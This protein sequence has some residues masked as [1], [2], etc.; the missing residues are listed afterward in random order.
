MKNI[1]QLSENLSKAIQ[2]IKDESQR[3]MVIY[4]GDLSGD[5]SDRVINTQRDNKG[6]LFSKY[7]EA[8][9]K[10]RDKKN[11]TNARKNFKFTGQMW[12]QFGVTGST[13]KSV[14]IGGKSSDSKDK[15][16]KNTDREGELIIDA[17]PKEL[18]KLE[19]KFRNWVLS[20]LK[21]V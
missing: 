1:S 8:Y 13:Q 17:S 7:S 19:E 3:Q 16:E 9:K 10:V 18:K 14:F 2:T 20:I 15:I 6:S 21:T 12:S 11:Y 5:I 4:A